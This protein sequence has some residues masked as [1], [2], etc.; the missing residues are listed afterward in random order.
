MC[1]MWQGVFFY[2]N[3]KIMSQIAVDTLVSRINVVIQVH[4][5][6]E[7]ITNAEVIGVL[8]MIKLDIYQECTQDDDE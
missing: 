3:S 8:E 7:D 1:W 5:D 6:A 4:R 2:G